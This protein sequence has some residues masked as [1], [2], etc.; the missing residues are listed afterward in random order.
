MRVDR[1]VQSD[2]K[3]QICF[4]SGRVLA[5]LYVAAT[6]NHDE[7][8]LIRELTD[9]YSLFCVYVAAI[10]NHDEYSLIR[11]LTDEYSHVLCV[12]CSDHKPRRVLADSRTH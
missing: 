12:C 1:L 6:T 5:V 11:E 3:L 9:A 7:Y 8:S 4:N 2:N 10:T